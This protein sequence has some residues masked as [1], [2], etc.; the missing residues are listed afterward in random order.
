MGRSN[1]K[2]VEW[3]EHGVGNWLK[4]NGIAEEHAAAF[5]VASKIKGRKKPLGLAGRGFGRIERRGSC[6]WDQRV[7]G[8]FWSAWGCLAP[9]AGAPVGLTCQMDPGGAPEEA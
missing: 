4:S 1:T 8:G 7:L 5:F 6:K 2:W 3:D 9:P